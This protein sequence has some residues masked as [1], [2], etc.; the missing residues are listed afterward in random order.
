MRLTTFKPPARNRPLAPPSRPAIL[1]VAIALALW[2]ATSR[3]GAS[4]SVVAVASGLF[5]GSCGFALGTVLYGRDS[6]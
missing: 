6:S 2:I 4:Q 1:L 5:F 3:L